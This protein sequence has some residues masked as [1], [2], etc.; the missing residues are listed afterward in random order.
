MATHAQRAGEFHFAPEEFLPRRLYEA[1]TEVRVNRP[2]I[3][4]A[5][6]G[7]RRKRPRLTLDGKLVIIATDHPGRRVTDL[8]TDPLVMGDRHSYLARGLRVLTAPGCDGIM[9]TTDFM[10]DLLIVNAL[11]RESGG[12]SLIDDKVLVGCMNRGGHAGVAGEIDDRFTSFTAGQLK[13]MNFDGGK[14]MYRLDPADDRSIKAV[15]DCAQAIT[16]LYREDLYAFLEP[17]SVRQKEGGGYETIKT[18]EALIR[19]TGAAAAMGESSLRTF[20]K[21][22]YTQGFERVAAA[23]TLPI[24]MLGGPAREDPTTVLDDFAAG[25][26]A[27]ANVRGVMVGRNVSFASREDPRALAAAVC[28]VVHEHLPPKDSREILAAERG[29]QMDLFAPWR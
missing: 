2:E 13:K 4:L 12:A 5:E 14:M 28:G 7:S 11:V 17:M 24:L 26:A 29:Q 15:S 6:A 22:S 3:V 1:I 18:V 8:G 19:D 23:T 25:M 21:L 27:G 9:G 16:D 20:L 10:E